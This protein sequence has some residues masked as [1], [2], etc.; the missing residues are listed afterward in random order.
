MVKGL[1][2]RAAATAG[3]RAARRHEAHMVDAEAMVAGAVCAGDGVRAGMCTAMFP[4]RPTRNVPCV[5]PSWTH[6]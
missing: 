5:D 1:E 6:G 2:A 3:V 4:G